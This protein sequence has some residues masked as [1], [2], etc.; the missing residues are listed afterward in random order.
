M[1]LSIFTTVYEIYKDKS[2]S[3]SVGYLHSP[4]SFPCVYVESSFALC[5]RPVQAAIHLLVC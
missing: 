5:G 2:D 4:C 1:Y 3:G